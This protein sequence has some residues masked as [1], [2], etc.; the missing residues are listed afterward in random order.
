MTAFSCRLLSARGG[1]SPYRRFIDHSIALQPH[2]WIDARL[3]SQQCRSIW[4]LSTMYQHDVQSDSSRSAD[5]PKSFATLLP[6]AP[7]LC[8]PSQGRV[9][10]SAAENT[11][12]LQSIIPRQRSLVEACN[13]KPSPARTREIFFGSSIVPMPRF[14]PIRLPGIAAVV[15]MR[16]QTIENE[17]LKAEVSTWCIA[18]VASFGSFA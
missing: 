3:H 10:V 1:T 15:I 7:G 9:V 18:W 14:V 16:L 13:R 6:P 8:S 12:G 11:G 2:P 5:P 4:S 17:F